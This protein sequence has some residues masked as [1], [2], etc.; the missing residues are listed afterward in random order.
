MKNLLL[1]LAVLAFL[2]VVSKATGTA[3]S[4]IQ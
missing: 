3:V 1:K 2:L 4:F